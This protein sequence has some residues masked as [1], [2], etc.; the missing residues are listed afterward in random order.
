MGSLEKADE[1]LIPAFPWFDDQ[2]WVWM[3]K[4]FQIKCNYEM[5]NDNLLDLS[6]LAYVHRRTLGGDPEI[7]FNAQMETTHTEGSVK[8]IRR[9]PDCEPPPTYLRMVELKGRIDRWQEIEFFPGLI[10]L[11]SGGVDVGTG[12]YEGRRE[13]GFQLR[14]FDAVTPESETSTLNLFCLGHNFRVNEPDVTNRL[15][16][17]FGNVLA[18]D[19]RVLEAQQARLG[20]P[21]S[22]SFVNLSVDAP[23]ILARR[24]LARMGAR[25]ASTD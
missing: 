6:H 8:V 17:E 19:I 10:T 22:D 11:Y 13:G 3:G 12:A 20:N 7:H 4:P 24:L 18:E 14:L 1:S 23:G 9:M 15:F 5:L 2:S 25:E 21:A 16:A